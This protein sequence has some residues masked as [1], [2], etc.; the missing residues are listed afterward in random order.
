[1]KYAKRY[2][3]LTRDQQINSLYGRT[4]TVNAKPGEAGKPQTS[5]GLDTP[6]EIRVQQMQNQFKYPRS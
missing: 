6:L 4:N 3:L 2:P 5:E 1:M